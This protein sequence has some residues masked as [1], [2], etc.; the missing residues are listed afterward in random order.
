MMAQLAKRFNESNIN[1]ILTQ[2]ASMK[3]LTSA[4][5]TL[6]VETNINENKKRRKKE[7]RISM[8]RYYIEKLFLGKKGSYCL[9]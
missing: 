4:L 1:V 7:T 5:R 6:Q 9:C 2:S 8:F 3:N